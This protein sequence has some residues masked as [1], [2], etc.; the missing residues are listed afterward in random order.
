MGYQDVVAG[1]M[2]AKHNVKFWFDPRMMTYESD[3]LHHQPG[4]HFLRV[5]PGKSPNDKSHKIL[6]MVAGGRIKAPNYFGPGGL[7]EFR[8]RTL[9]GEPFPIVQIPDREWFTGTPL[10]EW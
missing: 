7:R 6:E 2:L 8:E 9:R 10:S 5:D 3:E 1:A 4:Q